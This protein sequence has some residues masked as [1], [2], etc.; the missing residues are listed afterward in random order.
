MK[1]VKR[2]KARKVPKPKGIP[3]LLASGAIGVALL[4]TVVL[5]GQPK[6]DAQEMTLYKNPQCSCCEVYAA[7][8]RH[9]GY[10]VKVVPTHDLSLIKREHGVPNE[11][12]GC[13]TILVGNYVVE[14]H[15][16]VA[17]LNKLLKEK[18]SIKGIS[19]PGMPQ[20]SPGMG[21]SKAAPF[22]IYAIG[23]GG[24]PQVYAVE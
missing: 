19:L 22:S 18:P 3:A 11:L 12:D 1:P 20:G 4:I 6:A 9:N 10:D 24:E 5:L 13:H 21:G 7:Y 2:R 15:V 16:P 23:D 8:L 17:T 14:G